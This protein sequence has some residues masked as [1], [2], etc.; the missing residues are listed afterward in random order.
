MDPRQ[1]A[2]ME[3]ARAA[4]RLAVKYDRREQMCQDDWTDLQEALTELKNTWQSE[5]RQP[6]V[7]F[8][9]R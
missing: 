6:A 9:P 8:R 5:E 3:V 4:N 7:G 2:L 1:N